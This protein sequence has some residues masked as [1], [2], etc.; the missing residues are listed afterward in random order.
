[1]LAHHYG[2]FR[3]TNSNKVVFLGSGL[4]DILGG[5]MGAVSKYG[6]ST[7]ALDQNE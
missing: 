6:G 4:S 2:I 3:K 7:S 5:L 1:M